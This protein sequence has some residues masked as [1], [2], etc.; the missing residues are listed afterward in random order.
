[1]SEGWSLGA[2]EGFAISRRDAGEGALVAP[3]GDLDLATVEVLDTALRRAEETH[4]LVVLDLRQVPFMDSSG[5]HALIAAD[6][7][8]R[9]RGGRLAIVQGGDQIRRLLELT[10][11]DKQLEVVGDPAEVLSDPS[12]SPARTP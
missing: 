10:G 12:D 8:M 2:E 5:L 1:M 4:E 3:R 11:A 9:G 6:L 7:R